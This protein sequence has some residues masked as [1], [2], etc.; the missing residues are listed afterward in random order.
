METIEIEVTRKDLLKDF[1]DINDCP[2]ATAFK[3]K[4][5]G[6]EVRV[7][8][9]GLYLGPFGFEHKPVRYDFSGYYTYM[10]L[11]VQKNIFSWLFEG[12]FKMKLTRLECSGE[13]L[14]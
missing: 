13:L 12:G 3:R 10:V 14:N 1:L 5:P 4:F 2:I 7:S 9:D 11:R 8:S 6:S